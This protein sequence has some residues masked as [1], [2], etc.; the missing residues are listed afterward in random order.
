MQGI[1][2]HAIQTNTGITIRR[3]DP[4]GFKVF[5]AGSTIDTIEPSAPPT[6]PIDDG[7]E[8]TLPLKA[9]NNDSE[10]SYHPNNDKQSTCPQCK[11]PLP[12]NWIYQCC[13]P[14]CRTLYLANKP[15]T[16]HR[17]QCGKPLQQDSKHSF[18]SKVCSDLYYKV[19]KCIHCNGEYRYKSHFYPSCSEDCWIEESKPK[20]CT[21]CKVMFKLSYSKICSTC[22][23]KSKTTN[24]KEASQEQPLILPAPRSSGTQ[25]NNPPTYAQIAATQPVPITVPQIA[26]TP[27]P[28]TVPQA[29][30]SVK[31]FCSDCGTPTQGHRFCSDC[32][33]NMMQ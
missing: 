23:K 21:E 33:R 20:P 15:R 19:Q 3:N 29:I 26:T 16:C 8:T 31:R 13:S 2:T 22:F 10:A 27:V 7:S 5:G 24:T 9:D 12:A 30:R 32:G 17:Y 4:H 1:T 14:N 18:C 11:T 28:I 6:T 25:Q